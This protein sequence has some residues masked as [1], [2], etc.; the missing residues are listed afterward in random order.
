MYPAEALLILQSIVISYLI[1]Q[2]PF[3]K[4]KIAFRRFFYSTS[5][6]FNFRRYR[7]AKR[8][9]AHFWKLHYYISE[10]TMFLCVTLITKYIVEI[11]K[12]ENT[13]QSYLRA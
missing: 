4:A 6:K 1:N 13:S 10:V 11:C 7:F 5:T 9:T 8:M 3:L 2:I 12:H